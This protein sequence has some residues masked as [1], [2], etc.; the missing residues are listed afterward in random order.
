MEK[1]KKPTIGVKQSYDK[2][3]EQYNDYV[4][5]YNISILPKIKE[6]RKIT[7]VNKA[8][9][10]KELKNTMNTSEVDYKEKQPKTRVI[11][12]ESAMRRNIRLYEM[13]NIDNVTVGSYNKILE[14]Y[15]ILKNSEFPIRISFEYIAIMER[16]NPRQM[17]EYPKTTP[18]SDIL[19]KGEIMNVLHEQIERIKLSLETIQSIR[20]K[21]FLELRIQI[22][23]YRPSKVRG[24]LE[25]PD[26]LQKKKAL[27]NPKNDDDYCFWYCLICKL[28]WNDDTFDRVHVNRMTTFKQYNDFPELKRT[29][30]LNEM[31]KIEEIIN[32]NIFVFIANDGKI[33]PHHI[34]KHFDSSRPDLDLLLIKN[35]NDN[36]FVFIKDFNALMTNDNNT[37]KKIKNCGIKKAFHCKNCM[38]R[39]THPQKL[40]EHINNGKCFT[41]KGTST[42]LPKEGENILQ[43]KNFKNMTKNP[44]IL[45]ADFESVLVKKTRIKRTKNGNLVN[46][47]Y[48]EHVACGF[49]IHP[50]V[51]G[52]EN[53]E[54]FKTILYRG[55]DAGKM[56]LKKC[57]NLEENLIKHLKQ[58]VKMVIGDDDDVN[59]THC[60]MCKKVIVGQRNRDHCHLTGKFRGMACSKCNLNENKT[61]KRRINIPVVFHNLKGYD[62]HIIIQALKNFK[63]QSKHISIIANNFEKCMTFGIRQLKF[64]DSLNFLNASLGGLVENITKSDVKGLQP[65]DMF[66]HLQKNIK[67]TE[68]QAELL[69]R[70]GV[71]PYSYMT[72]FKKFEEEQLPEKKWFYNDLN[73]SHISD[74]DYTHAQNVWEKL[75]IKNMGEYHDLYLKTDV[76][77]LA[78]VFEKFRDLSMQTYGLD[79]AYYISLPSYSWDSMLKFTGIELE[80]LTDIDM[81]QMIESGI[82]GGVSSVMQ[83]YA[84]ANNKYMTN[85]DASKPS[86]FIEY[87]DANNLYGKSQ[88]MKMPYKDFKFIENIGNVSNYM[89]TEEKGYILEVDLEYCKELHDA[90]NCLP[91]APEN[92]IVKNSML[93][94]YQQEFGR[95]EDTTAKLCPNLNDKTKYVI[96][97]DNLKYYMEKGLKLLKIHRVIEFSH[98]AFLEPYIME[99]TRLRTGARND[100]EKDFYKLMNNA[101]FGKTMENVR[102]RRDIHISTD[103]DHYQKLVNKPNFHTSKIFVASDDEN[104]NGIVGVELTKTDVTLDKPIYCGF[105]ILEL[106]KIHMYKFHYD[107]IKVKYGDKAKLMF[108]DTD[109]L[110]YHIET[111]DLQMDFHK[112]GEYFDF[113]GLDKS[114]F[115]FSNKNKKVLGKFK[116]ETNFQIIEEIVCLCS[117]MY[118]LKL[119]VTDADRKREAEMEKAGIE[120]EKLKTEKKAGKGVPKY[121]IKKQTTFEQYKQCLNTGKADMVEFTKIRSVNHTIM[122]EKVKKVGLSNFDNKRYIL[123]N[124]IMTLAHG[125]KDIV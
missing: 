62:G 78:D 41:L 125:H 31:E 108:T 27:F 37:D 9:L 47:E 69:I 106:S 63:I 52:D 10:R 84:K 73:E 75:N 98:K 33:H 93:S 44:A 124:G 83:R 20:F 15:S 122:S 105:S 97:C 115:A 101:V 35:G 45:Y 25:L 3:R 120:F 95:K 13:Q 109:S 14:F 40:H 59:A 104:A 88:C 107:Y 16:Q 121:K 77:L 39:F 96:H 34:T 19:N 56:F 110:T 64:I 1:S 114:H 49:C 87:V 12:K 76:L 85:Y 116:P 113:S 36:H 86:S 74:D 80:L 53:N 111:E 50:V 21:K 22:N 61:D 11:F 117:K 29:I 118:A 119:Q 112:D 17:F 99:N 89:S 70:K 103:A 55:E 8:L 48:D 7:R 90:H 5:A 123:P 102:N 58:N 46:E 81:Y 82:R 28:H 54:K 94:Q 79:P 18:H 51:I 2:L 42:C 65:I 60:W 43:F 92:I 91:L 32:M 24:F 23:K 66:P 57:F 4:D 30:K 38:T 71:Y 68:E 26:F 100:F 67:P 6:E 72:S